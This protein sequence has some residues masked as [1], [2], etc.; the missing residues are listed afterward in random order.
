MSTSPLPTAHT[1]GPRRN[2]RNTSRT[3]PTMITQ[4]VP[5]N[6]S[7]VDKWVSGCAT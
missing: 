6:E 7:L 3:A 5:V 1:I 2:R 4:F